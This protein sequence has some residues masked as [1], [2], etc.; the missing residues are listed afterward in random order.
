MNGELRNKWL[1]QQKEIFGNSV[2]LE[3]LD[4]PQFNEI[5]NLED[6]NKQ[7]R[8]CQNCTLGATRTNFVFGIGNPDADL[9]FV[10]EAPGKN[11][12]LQGEPFVG[13]AGKLLDNILQTIGLN[14]S[15]V[16][17]LNVLKCRPPKNRNPL[18]HELEQCEPYLKTQLKIIQ[19]KLII[20]LGKVA[21]QTLLRIDISLSKM[22]EKTYLYENIDVLVTYHP[23]ALLRNPALKRPTWEDFKKIKTK[24]LLEGIS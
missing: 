18:P 8:N 13:M 10:G 23:A 19:P 4:N 24:Y 15:K 7:I 5:P 6:F 22:R 9:V 16:Y 21:A 11:E 12:D 3:K 2:F 1:L 14:R 20:A 17:I